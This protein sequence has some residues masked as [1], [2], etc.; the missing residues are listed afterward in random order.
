LPSVLSPVPSSPIQY[1][2]GTLPGESLDTAAGGASIP[3]PS[4][5]IEVPMSN[6]L[7][8]ILIILT[9]IP[10]VAL[11]KRLG[12]SR[13]WAVIS[14]VPILGTI[15]ILWFVTFRRWPTVL[16][17]KERTAAVFDCG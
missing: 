10:S 5:G 4:S 8:L 12:L 2:A 13:W 11:L 15:A 7:P 9:A 14:I 6:L 1:L 3:K 16:E 17:G